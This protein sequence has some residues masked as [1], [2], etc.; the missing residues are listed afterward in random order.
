[1]PQEIND[2]YREAEQKIAEALDQQ[3]TE[4]NLGGWL[5]PDHKLVELPPSLRQLTQ[6][7]NLIYWWQQTY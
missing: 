5:D 3:L 4:V 6:L 1:M 7:E 2:A